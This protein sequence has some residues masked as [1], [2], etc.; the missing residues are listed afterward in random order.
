MKTK[1][2]IYNPNPIKI[3]RKK[4]DHFTISLIIL[5]IKKIKLIQYL[6]KKK[7]F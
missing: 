7:Y 4:I 3:V 1:K 5:S 2:L 6:K